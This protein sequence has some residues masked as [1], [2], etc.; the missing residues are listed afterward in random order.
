MHTIVMHY[1]V[2]FVGV[3]LYV[4]LLSA[5]TILL[6]CEQITFVVHFCISCVLLLSVVTHVLIRVACSRHV[7]SWFIICL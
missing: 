2:V 5:M 3:W 1:C 7:E 6:C 4:I